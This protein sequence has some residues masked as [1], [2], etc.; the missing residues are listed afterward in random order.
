[1]SWSHFREL[2]PLKQPLQREFYAE[3]CRVEGWSVRTLA[4]RIDSMLYERTALSR[5]PQELMKLELQA[6]RAKG[7]LTP[8]LVLK[9]P[10][11][12]DF[13]GLSDRYVERDLEDAI[14]RE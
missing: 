2:L 1:M 7:E 4:G 9:D 5:K 3:M 14:L 8:T 11:V 10:Y 12:L 6:L 13:M